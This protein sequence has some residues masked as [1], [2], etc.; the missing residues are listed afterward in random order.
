MRGTGVGMIIYFEA[1]R[2]ERFEMLMHSGHT[3]LLEVEMESHK[4]IC[5][6]VEIHR[7]RCEVQ[8]TGRGK[9][10]AEKC[11]RKAFSQEVATVR[12]LA[13]VQTLEKKLCAWR[14][15]R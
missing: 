14:Q 8:S 2:C 12:R 4:T 9:Y 1:V 10:S 13:I 3:Q 11:G 6:L 7:R 5:R 15:V